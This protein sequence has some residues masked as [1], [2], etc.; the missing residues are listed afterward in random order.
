MTRHLLLRFWHDHYHHI[1]LTVIAALC[2]TL[3][4]GFVG[5]FAAHDTIVRLI[6]PPAR[7]LVAV[8]TPTHET[9]HGLGFAAPRRRVRPVLVAGGVLPPAVDLSADAPPVGDQGS[10]NACVSW[11]LAYGLRAWYARRDDA[12]PAGGF[13][14]M[15]TY[16][17]VSG[18]QNVPTSFGATLAVL[19]SQGVDTAA[20]YWQGPGNYWTPP[21]A[22][23]HINAA[24]Y[25]TIA[26]R[27][28]FAG[29]GQGWVAQ[30]AIEQALASGNP[31]DLGIPVYANFYSAGPGSYYIDGTAGAFYGGHA[32]AVYR[33][34]ANGVWLENSWGT[35]WGLNGWAELSWSFVEQYAYE[36]DQLVMPQAA[37]PTPAPTA[38]PRPRPTARPPPTPTPRPRPKPHPRPPA[39][40]VYDRITH[41]TLLRVGP[42]DF[43][44][45]RTLLTTGQ[46][47]K[48]AGRQTPHWRDVCVGRHCGWVWR[49]YTRRMG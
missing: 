22:A 28:L 48:D 8:G 25:R 19:A 10:V 18:G 35:G 34:D 29:A 27:T 16:S 2:A 37:A 33:Y 46:R 39:R 5:G 31:V 30:Q 23:E 41:R 3:I 17:Q 44:R 7:A 21:T 6:Q 14:P 32:V 12:Y 45:T 11:A 9:R 15:Y 26:G 4:V 36:A 42:R 20:D 40:P 38:T 47:V 43:P 49:A 1:Y 13:A 24:P